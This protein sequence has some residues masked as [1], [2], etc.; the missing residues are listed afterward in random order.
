VV[1]FAVAPVKSPS[2]T[3]N[4]KPPI[5]GEQAV[6]SNPTPEPEATQEPAPSIVD[7]APSDSTL[8][9]SMR[10]PDEG[11]ETSGSKIATDAWEDRLRP[12]VELLGS[13]PVKLRRVTLAA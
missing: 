8:I 7:L 2:E 13:E 12:L 9:A 1:W 3:V 4:V 11:A 6:A 10:W 5:A